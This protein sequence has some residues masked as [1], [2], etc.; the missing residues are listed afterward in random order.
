M[1]K[2]VPATILI[3]AFLFESCQ[4]AVTF[5]KP[6]PENVKSLTSFPER[7]QGKYLSAD[8]ASILTISDKL[9]TRNYDFYLEQHTDSLGSSYKLLGDTLFDIEKGTKEKIAVNGDAI[10][11]HA[12]WTDTLFKISERN[13]LKKFKGHYF[14]NIQYRQ[15]AWEVK[16]LSLKNGL[17]TISSISEKNDIQKLRDIQRTSADTV[18]T[19]F[20]LTRKQFKRFV[21]SEGFSDQEIFTRMPKNGW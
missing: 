7:L 13:I 1:K 2:S 8:Q 5:D 17:I 15:N 10:I 14:L 16:K 6:Q 21:K 4:P 3:F 19:Q 18:S 9:I 20:V 11:Q 12:H